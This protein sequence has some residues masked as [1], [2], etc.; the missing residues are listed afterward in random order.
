MGAGRAAV[1]SARTQALLLGTAMVAGKWAE[2]FA[3]CK[4]STL[5]LHG[6]FGIVDTTSVQFPIPD[7]SFVGEKMLGI[8]LDVLFVPPKNKMVWTPPTVGDGDGG[9][10]N[11]TCSAQA[12]S[13]T[14]NVR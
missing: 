1:N 14:L 4:T 5:Y 11:P 8:D 3:R 10:I 7:N 13:T 6:C 12:V 2:G 9:G